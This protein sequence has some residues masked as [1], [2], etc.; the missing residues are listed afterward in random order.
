MYLVDYDT[1]L[2]L[3][4]LW[5]KLSKDH[6]QIFIYVSYVVLT[7]TIFSHLSVINDDHSDNPE[8]VMNHLD[9]QSLL[10]LGN[11]KTQT[12]YQSKS[13]VALLN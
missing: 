10:C 9:Q 6:F 12:S 4:P 7:S 13:K 8:T 1:G 2:L 3:K 11:I 5:S